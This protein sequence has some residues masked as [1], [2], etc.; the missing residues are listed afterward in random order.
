MTYQDI[1]DLIT[2]D[3]IDQALEMITDS[4]SKNEY[5]VHLIFMKCI[6]LRKKN[7]FKDAIQTF[8]VLINLQP[9]NA[10][11]YSELGVTYF[12]A[13]DLGNA[14]IAMDKSV[15]LEPSNSYRYSSRAY[16]KGAMKD[17]E[18]AVADYR[19]AVELDPE[20]PIALNN[21]G[22]LEEQL[23]RANSAKD[24]FKEADAMAKKHGLNIFETE[25]PEKAAETQKQ[26]EVSLSSETDSASSDS[27]FKTMLSVFRSKQEF[28]NYLT[29]I[30]SAFQK[31]ENIDE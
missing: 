20:D 28:K 16:I 24:L 18:G 12:H 23:G 14:M 4:L 21:L 9:N 31:K 27:L 25:Q 10:T 22:L 15:A 8:D 29:F 2:Q 3:K 1:Q 6:A 19:K 26:E 17:T 11:Y 5:D 30:R 13:K 7:L